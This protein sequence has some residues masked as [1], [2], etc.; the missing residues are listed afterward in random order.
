MENKPLITEEDYTLELQDKGYVI[1]DEMPFPP[2]IGEK[3]VIVDQDFIDS[4]IDESVRESLNVGDSFMMPI[5]GEI[6]RKES[7][8]KTSSTTTE[9]IP[10]VP[11]LSG[12]SHVKVRTYMGKPIISED[13][14]EVNGKT[15]NVVR[16]EDGSTHDLTVEEYEREVVAKNN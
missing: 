9:V 4:Q 8:T 6:P 16:L 11:D 12:T 3:E 14:R 5:L 1:G 7:A 10:E 13:T 15:Y 2:I